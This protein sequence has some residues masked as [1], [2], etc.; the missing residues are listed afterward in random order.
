VAAAGQLATEG[1][2]SRLHQESSCL[3]H[4]PAQDE[5]LRVENG[6]DRRES[7]A[8]PHSQIDQQLDGA[9]IPLHRCPSHVLPPQGAGVPTAQLVQT[10]RQRRT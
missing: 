5:Q 10:C 7:L 9:R 3:G 6:R 2:Q 8:D 4:S 1:S